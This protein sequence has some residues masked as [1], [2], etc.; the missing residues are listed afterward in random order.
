[1]EILMLGNLPESDSRSIGGATVLTQEI[2]EYLKKQEELSVHFLKIRKHWKPKAQIID[3]LIFPFRFIGNLKRKDAI[4]IHASSD[5]HLTMGPIIVLLAKFFKKP[6]TYH[7]FGG[8]FHK[9][10]QRLPKFYQKWLLKTIFQ[11]KLVFVETLEMLH[12]FEKYPSVSMGWL[13]NSRKPYLGEIDKNSIFQKKIVFISRVTPSKGIEELIAAVE[14]LDSSYSIDI[15]GPLDKAYYSE[16]HFRDKAINYKGILKSEAVI[17][18][19]LKYDLLVL[20]T[21]HNGEGYPGILLEAL[22][23]GIPV[24][25]TEW[26]ALGEIIKEDYNGKLIPIK[27]VEKLVEAIQYFSEE[28]YPPFRANALESFHNFNSE[29]VFKRLLESYD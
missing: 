14:I 17:Q 24:I 16:E 8:N 28:N 11:S 12:F 23:V 2:F 26:N 6:V 4:D 15:Y 27:S 25:T 19:L 13:P 22:S 10:F 1:M 29:V 18:T 21:F 3:Y 9:R 5:F 20:P 7:F